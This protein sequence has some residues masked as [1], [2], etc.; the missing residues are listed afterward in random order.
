MSSWIHTTRGRPRAA[1]RT[2]PRRGPRLTGRAAGLLAVV[3]VLAMTLVVPLRQYAAQRERVAELSARVD[4][5]SKAN[6]RLER[7]IV[8]LRDPAYLERLARECLG[9][10]KPGEI[11]FVTVPGKGGRPRPAPAC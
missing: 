10:V 9:M 4:A 11:A 1:T 6:A 3:L 7:R 2:V 5:L 8:Q